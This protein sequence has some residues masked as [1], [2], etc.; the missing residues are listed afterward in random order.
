MD[1][2][3]ALAQRVAQ[4]ESTVADVQRTLQQV[5][6]ALAAHGIAVNAPVPQTSHAVQPPLAPSTTSQPAAL[7]AATIGAA[8]PT[9]AAPR[10]S[11][12][13][14][15]DSEFWLNKIGIG[16]LLLGVAF[17][18]RYSIDQG[19]VTPTVRVLFGLV[20]GFSLIGMG[21]WMRT[22]RAAF[23]QVLQGGGVGTLYISGFA[24]FQFYDLVPYPIAF[25]FMCTVTLLAFILAVWQNAV[26]LALIAAV[27]GL[28]T[29]FLLDT[30]TGNVAGLIGYTCLILTGTSAI[31]VYRGWRS[32]LLTTFVGV[33]L[34]L[35]ISTN[36]LPF[37]ADQGVFERWVVQF[38]VIWSWLAFW[39]LPIVRED[40]QPR[41]DSQQATPDIKLRRSFAH[42][43]LLTLLT[44]AIALT[45]S[46][47]TWYLADSTW[48]W[49]VLGVAALYGLVAWLLRGTANAGSL[50]YTHAIG[51][52]MLLT[53]SFVLLLA[54]NVLLFALAAQATAILFVAQRLNDQ[55]VAPLGH[56]LFV[57]LGLWLV[58]RLTDLRYG[59]I[60]VFNA[61]A[62]TELAVLGLALAASFV[63]RPRRI[64]PI[65]WLAIHVLFLI[66]LARELGRLPSGN[67]YT[68]I[69]WGAYAI[70][71]LVAG[72]RRDR[73][74]VVMF[75]IGTLLLVVGKLFL[76]DL[77]TLQ[78]I[79]R[80]LL[81]LGFGGVFLT[82]SYFFQAL[83]RQTPQ[84]PQAP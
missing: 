10:R 82:L 33:W 83:W 61:E 15:R 48:G 70:A 59:Q 4:L 26:V 84:P 78:A 60:A 42:L 47:Q 74:V 79:W 21:L 62:L 44:P 36:S 73:S 75:G 2:S 30:G 45:V 50:A 18:F 52:L 71:L 55:R 76:I 77:S 11:F 1:D 16:L 40:L 81:F 38:G 24:S 57:G 39:V 22:T 72:L 14:V 5:Y 17:L 53:T 6:G 35:L 3:R 63:V 54:G 51:A 65:Y 31:Y 23:S 25:G 67:G 58:L 68:T 19:W 32:L 34:I 43:H 12:D 9:P 64:A 28:G 41:A 29:P 56:L 27:G 7:P 46:A 8:Q 69:A 80:I 13:I 49:I 20:L 37:Y 66:W